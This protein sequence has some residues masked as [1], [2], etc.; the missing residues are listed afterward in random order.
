MQAGDLQ[1]NPDS[2]LQ[3]APQHEAI[4][5]PGGVLTRPEYAIYYSMV[6][7]SMVY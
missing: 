7:F 5:S 1:G 3:G 6:C 2:D 4:G